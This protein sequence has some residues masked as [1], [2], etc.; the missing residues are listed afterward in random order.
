M[1]VGNKPPRL[2]LPPASP[3]PPPPPPPQIVAC[4]VCGVRM[5][6]AEVNEHLD[7]CLFEQHEREEAAEAQR[8]RKQ[9]PQ[10]TKRE[11]ERRIVSE[12]G[13]SSSSSFTS[14]SSAMPPHLNEQRQQRS[15][16]P[17][18]PTKP[19]VGFYSTQ[20]PFQSQPTDQ[21]KPFRA[22]APAQQQ[23]YQFP[24]VPNGGQADR[25]LTISDHNYRT[26]EPLAPGTSPAMHTFL[27]QLP[28][29]CALLF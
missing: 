23:L 6:E 7:L 20:Q 8:R 28:L 10:A 11:K 3:T 18:Q 26:R 13:S 27:N 9:Q 12:R 22:Q 4:P 2:L 1:I 14:S 5:I 29:Q 24:S 25:S 21:Y 15:S 16:L 17:S 19:S